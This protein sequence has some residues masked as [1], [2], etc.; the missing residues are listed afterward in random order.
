MGTVLIIVLVV[1]AL[2]VLYGVLAYNGMVRS[3][4]MVD[5]AWSGID[6]QLKRRHDLI[7][8]LVET[9]KGYAAHEKGVFEAV[10]KARAQAMQAQR[11]GGSRAQP[12]ASSARRWAGCSRS[13]RPTRSSAPTRELPAAAGRADQHRGP[14]L[15]LAAHLQRQRPVVQ[16]QDPDVPQLGD[17]RLRRVHQAGLLRDRDAGRP[18]ARARQ[19]LRPTVRSRDTRPGAD[20]SGRSTAARGSTAG[21]LVARCRTSWSSAPAISG[22]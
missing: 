20:N 5:E 2:I 15:R 6:V 7:P 22:A 21:D 18:R 17:R 14:D 19:L 12:R 11:P 3:R 4:N 16:H 1:V 13:P 9:V 8:N 10:T